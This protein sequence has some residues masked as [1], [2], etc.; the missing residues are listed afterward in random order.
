M[1]MN[2]LMWV[3]GIWKSGP[4]EE[5]EVLLTMESSLQ[6]VVAFLLT[7]SVLVGSG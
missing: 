1:V 4:V 2:P 7:L 6:S 5:P 3:L